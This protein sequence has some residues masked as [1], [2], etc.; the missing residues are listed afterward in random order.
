MPDDI[1]HVTQLAVGLCF[2]WAAASKLA[3]FARFEQGVASF[4]ILVPAM[5]RKAAMAVVLLESLVAFCLLA[6]WE[7]LWGAGIAVV[8]LTVF[9]V[10]IASARYRGVAATC[11]CFGGDGGESATPRTY[12]RIALLG[13]GVAAVLLD[14]LASANVPMRFSAT[15]LVAAACVSV[16]C[17]A[18]T[19]A[20]EA[21]SVALRQPD[22]RRSR[23]R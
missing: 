4:E 9:A 10:V 21:F 12:L 6:G 23:R 13:A 8:L 2:A 19:D 17:A 1:A 18:S 11:A 22:G 16:G 5:V 20:A 7:R 14:V 15:A 3:T